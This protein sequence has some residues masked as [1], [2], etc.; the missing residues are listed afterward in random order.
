MHSGPD[1]SPKIIQALRHLLEPL[2]KLL[3]NFGMAFPAF[4]EL[5]KRVYVDVA[6][7]H[8]AL[9]GKPQSDSRISLITGVHRKDVKRLRALAD[10]PL[11]LGAHSHTSLQSQLLAKWLGDPHYLDQDAHPLPLARLASQCPERSFEQMVSDLSKD[12]R[13]RVFLDEWLRKGIALLDENDRVSLNLKALLQAPGEEEKIV[14]FGRNL[15]DH[16]AASISNIEG[17]AAPYMDR[18]VFYHGLTASQV[19]QL[20]ARAEQLSMDALL[21]INRSARDMLEHNQGQV[22][23]TQRMH[24]GAYFYHTDQADTHGEN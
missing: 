24:F 23:A 7:R 17:N 10:E 3:L 9:N 6:D 15:H 14:F 5:L 19:Q 2:V 12:V 13:P 4:S 1:P 8:F 11:N 21:E 20:K 22:E 18:C 16:L